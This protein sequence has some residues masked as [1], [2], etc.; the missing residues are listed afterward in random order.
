M[1]SYPPLRTSHADYI[2]AIVLVFRTITTYLGLGVP[3]ILW[4]LWKLPLPL[5]DW[6]AKT[7][8]TGFYIGSWIKGGKVGLHFSFTGAYSRQCLVA[9]IPLPLALMAFGSGLWLFFSGATN[10]PCSLYHHGEWNYLDMNLG[11]FLGILAW[12]H[13]FSAVNQVFTTHKI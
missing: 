3:R 4:R 5:Y 2:C 11:I 6:L 10:T 9:W 1:D 13:I 7:G 12:L 8:L